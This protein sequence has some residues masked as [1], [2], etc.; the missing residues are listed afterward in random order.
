MKEHKQSSG[1]KR[2]GRSAR[3]AGIFLALGVTAGCAVESTDSAETVARADEALYMTGAA[4]P[5][6]VVRVCWSA[7]SLAR[8]TFL[9]EAATVRRRAN[10]EWPSAARVTFVGWLPCPTN[11]GGMTVIN[12]DNS[13]AA[14][15]NVGYPG[16]TGT[17]TANLGT[18]RSDFATG[19]IP[20]EFGHLLG[21][22]HEH[23]R[24]DFDHPECDGTDVTGGNTLGTAPD[25]DSIMASTGYCQTNPGLSAIDRQGVLVAYGARQDDFATSSTWAT[26]VASQGAEFADVNGDGRADL[27]ARSSGGTVQLGLSNGATFG[28]RTTVTTWDPTYSFQLVDVNRDGR[29]DIVGRKGTDVQVALSTGTGFTSSTQWTT[30]AAAYDLQVADVNGD[31]RGDIIGRSGTDVQVALSTGTSFSGS[32]GWITW[33]A[34][35]DAKFADVDGDGRADII[36]RSGTSVRVGLST[37]AGF[38]APTQWTTWGTSYDHRF[39]DVNGDGRADLIGRAGNNVQVGLSTAVSGNQFA[40]STQWTTWSS[41]YDLNLADTT[42]DGAAD[43]CGRSGL[44]VQVGLSTN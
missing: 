37:G 14:N 36:G 29:A 16:S 30:W 28:A 41:S 12:L 42:G 26:L 24:P 9:A 21:F 11:T 31:G 10:G 19:L 17:D 32:T 39:A 5:N 33:L 25:F 43:I 27:I 6:G 22:H 20:H 38:S 8:G 1:I 3:C 15:A 2:V 18:A 35:F 23:Q 4:W 34:G 44:D 40:A 13:T 7:T